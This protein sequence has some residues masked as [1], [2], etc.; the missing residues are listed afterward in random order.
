VAD[1]TPEGHAAIQRD[2]DGLEK[3]ANRY[4]AKFSKEKCK[5]L[6]LVTNNPMHQYMLGA[7]SWKVAWQKG[8]WGSWWTPS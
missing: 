5:V 1:G 2:L 3:W 7:P 4:F 8:V 6:Q